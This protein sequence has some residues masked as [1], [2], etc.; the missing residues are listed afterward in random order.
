MDHPPLMS[1]SDIESCLAVGRDRP[2]KGVTIIGLAELEALCDT[3]RAAHHYRQSLE[4]TTA[5]AEHR[6]MSEQELAELKRKTEEYRSGD[7]RRFIAS[8]GLAYKTLEKSLR[9]IQAEIGKWATS[10]FGDNLSK[11]RTSPA[12]LHPLGELAPLLGV[13]E[14]VGELCHV[15]VYRH[16]GRGFS[17]DA[18]YRAGVEDAL[19][20]I[21]VFL[22]DFA[23]RTGHD[24]QSCL[25]KVW[26][27]VQK[28]R[29]AD[30][31]GSKAAET[32][33]PAPPGRAAEQAEPARRIVKE[34]VER[35]HLGQPTNLV[36]DPTAPRLVSCPEGEHYDPDH[37][38]HCA[39]CGTVWDEGMDKY[40][41]AAPT[42]PPVKMKDPAPERKRTRTEV[43]VLRSGP[44]G[45][46]ERYA[47]VQSCDCLERAEADNPGASGAAWQ[48]RM[49][50]IQCTTCGA[51]STT[52][53][54]LTASCHCNWRADVRWLPPGDDVSIG[55]SARRR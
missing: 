40:T 37:T 20:D 18:E 15:V 32:G 43:L 6:K 28:R 9:E 4:E 23:S 26:A 36:Y 24:L 10:Q 27:K 1:L 42:A 35:V 21:M 55:L 19:A 8:A 44:G 5:P 47:N 3:A 25:G 29:A 30:W 41:K 31:A 51:G 53:I 54:G 22:C 7:L 16:Q 38:G 12:H 48:V 33:D 13:A 52:V 50:H 17:D 2:H 14:E 34:T 11:D 39:R 45:C 46:C 49:G